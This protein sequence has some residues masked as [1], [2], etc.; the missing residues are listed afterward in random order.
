MTEK[1]TKAAVKALIEKNQ[2]VLM[3]KVEVGNEYLWVPPGGKIKHGEAPIDALHRE[4]DEETGMDI[5]VKDCIGM[6][7]FFIGPDNK[8]DQVSLTVFEAST[9]SHTV[10]IS[11]N[12]ANEDIEG[13]RWV[14][15]EKLIEKNITDSL[16][17][18]LKDNYDLG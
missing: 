14:K 17:D 3:L 13:Y 10:D 5:E 16:S 9:E 12:P 4:I 1:N 7:H 6:Y 15:P 2:K 18:L 8:G 11:S